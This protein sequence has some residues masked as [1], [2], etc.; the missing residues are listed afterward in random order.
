MAQIFLRLRA[1]SEKEGG[2]LPEPILKLDWRYK[3][4]GEPAPE[5]LAKELNGYANEDITDPVDP[6]KVVIA[7]GKQLVNFSVLRDN[8][9]TTCGCWI[10][11][12]CFNEAG[13][14]MARRDN[15]DPDNTGVFPNW[16][17]WWRLSMDRVIYNR[18]WADVEGN[19]WDRRKLFWWERTNG[20]VTKDVPDIAPNAKPELIRALYH[21]CAR[22]GAAVR[23]EPN[24]GRPISSTLRTIKI[25]S[26]QPCDAKDSRQSGIAGIE[27]RLAT[28]RRRQRVSLRGTSYRLTDHF[29]FWTK[30]VRFNAVI[31]P[32]FFVE[33]SE[34]LA[35]EKGIKSGH[36]VQ[37]WS[38]RGSVKAKAVVTKR[39]NTLMCDGKP[40]HVIGI[41]LHWG[42][43]GETKEGFGPNSLTPYVGDANSDTPEYKAFRRYQ[44]NRRT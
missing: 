41:P 27:K 28:V 30:H 37:V 18:A 36:W 2:A 17:W 33:I 38:K 35:A 22:S 13:N 23:P 32:E 5:E 16:A 7:K 10:Y 9:K 11:S 34:Q 25:A 15:H 4:P 6:T 14:N 8:G 29:H 21:E 26:R 1:L 43:I 31:Q 24:A 40:V 42:F 12:G 3:D 20:L 44:T 39:I 19:P